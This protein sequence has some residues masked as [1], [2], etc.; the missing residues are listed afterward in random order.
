M[1]NHKSAAKRARQNEKRRLRNRARRSRARTL[2]KRFRAAAEGGDLEAAR[3][4]FAAAERELRK[5]ASKG[6]LK[7]PTVSRRISRLA[8]LLHRVESGAR[9]AS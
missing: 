8:R 9:S 5:A 1:A 3:A 7:K 6:V 4:G 2:V